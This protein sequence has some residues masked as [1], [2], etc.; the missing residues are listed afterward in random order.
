MKAKMKGRAL[1]L[2]S[3]FIIL[4]VYAENSPVGEVPAS[5]YHNHI[6]KM[7]SFRESLLQQN[8]PSISPTSAPVSFN[9]DLV[10]HIIYIYALDNLDD[11]SNVKDVS[12]PRVYRVTSYGGDPR[13]KSD[14][15]EAIMRAISDAFE[16]PSNGFLMEGIVNLGGA[17]INLE[18]GNYL[19]SRPLRL[20]NPGYGNLMVCYLIS[21][22]C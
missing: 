13:G 3:S 10:I 15:T 20:P 1:V 19:I 17:Q 4:H 7:Q 21:D 6:R 22:I 8:S 11:V 12:G 9:S 14:S 16:G 2:L 5:R 18:G